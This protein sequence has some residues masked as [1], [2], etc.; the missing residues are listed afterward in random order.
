MA[1]KDGRKTKKEQ[2]SGL[3]EVCSRSHTRL[4]VL[5]WQ[6]IT[7]S[8]GRKYTDTANSIYTQPSAQLVRWVCGRLNNLWQSHC[9]PVPKWMACLDPLWFLNLDK[10]YFARIVLSGYVK[11]RECLV[12]CSDTHLL[13]CLVKLRQHPCRCGEQPRKRP[14]R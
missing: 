4:D 12:L 2:G 1:E 8:A 13:R 14:G 6:E 10:S 7:C 9:A 5:C 11:I 3:K